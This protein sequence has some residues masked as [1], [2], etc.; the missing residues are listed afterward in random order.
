M[1]PMTVRV[2]MPMVVAVFMIVL[3]VDMLHVA[4][5]RHHEDMPFRAHDLDLRAEQP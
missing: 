3:M 5:A 4:A 2:T 1:M